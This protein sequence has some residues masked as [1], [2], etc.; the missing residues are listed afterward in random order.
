MPLTRSR[1][2]D[3]AKEEYPNIVLTTRANIADKI[4]KIYFWD[5]R[6]QMMLDKKLNWSTATTK[7]T[8]KKLKAANKSPSHATDIE[9]SMLT[10]DA[11]ESLL[12]E[13]A[14]YPGFIDS[15]NWSFHTLIQ[16]KHAEI[17]PE[18]PISESRVAQTLQ[19][20]HPSQA[21]PSL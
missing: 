11:I 10:G 14:G 12:T 4:K 15:E 7:E 5:K 20:E 2:S 19:C 8:S 3:K 13:A 1:I 9:R 18:K 17:A 21:E 6:Y 16:I